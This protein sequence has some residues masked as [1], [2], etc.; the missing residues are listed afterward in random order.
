MNIIHKIA[1]AAPLTVAVLSGCGSDEP[2]NGGGS[3]TPVTPDG[4]EATTVDSR[5][6]YE[7]NPAF[8]GS[9]DCLKK[10]QADLP[11]IAD[12]G[13]DV[14][15]LMPI[16]ERGEL[17][18]VG[19]PYC[20]R[21]YKKVNPAYGTEEDVRNLVEAAHQKGMKVILDWVANHT[22]WDNAWVSTNP[23]YF[24]KDASGNV[25]ATP[26][27]GD[28]AQLDYSV[29]GTRDTM[30]DAMLY[31]V[32]RCGIDGYRCDYVEGVPHDFW[33]DAVATLK[34]KDSDFIMLAETSKPDYYADGFDMIYDWNFSGTLSNAFSGKTATGVISKSD[35]IMAKVPEGKSILRYVFNHDVAAEN[36]VDRMYGTPEGVVAAYAAATMLDGTPLVYSSMDVEGLTGKQSFFTYGELAFSDRLSKEYGAI[37]RAYKKTAG[38]RG[39]Q[40][41]DYTTSDVICYTR[42]AGANTMLVMVN[43]TGAEIE[44]RTPISL[45]GED[46]DD[47]IGGAKVKVPLVEKLEPYAYRIYMK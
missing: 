41:S 32:E 26:S 13:C 9:K 14:L 20:V 17:K 24:A 12:M 2:E 3:Q 31:W 44:F 11:R 19:S 6:I 1:I 4:P 29:Q 10:L 45:S 5:V 34:D 30:K 40:L 47:L 16:Y 42:K 38:V 23:E 8:W 7:A 37:N 28:V 22:A 27:W 36:N 35:E 46:M 15:W 25:A 39:G 18:A 33:K 43:T 21:D